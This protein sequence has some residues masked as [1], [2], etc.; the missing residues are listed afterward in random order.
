MQ[1]EAPPDRSASE[2]GPLVSLPFL[3]LLVGIGGGVLG[4]L[5]RIALDQGASLRDFAIAQAKGYEIKGLALVMA[6]TA[7]ATA[8]A[9]GLVR[10]IAP[11]ASGSGIPMWK[12]CSRASPSR[13]R[14][15]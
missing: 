4:V 9:A 3:A 15:D 13:R 11:A 1:P 12:Q 7:L 6:G 5:F 10:R 14:R 8:L 2:V